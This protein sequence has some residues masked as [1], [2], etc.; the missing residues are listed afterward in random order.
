MLT[1]YYIIWGYG[2]MMA[3]G[4]AESLFGHVGGE[5]RGCCQVLMSHE[6]LVQR[7]F[8]GLWVVMACSGVPAHD[9][10]LLQGYSGGSIGTE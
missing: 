3:I 9:H 4:D 2:E 8:V 1:E 10:V 5:V 7:Q 6:W